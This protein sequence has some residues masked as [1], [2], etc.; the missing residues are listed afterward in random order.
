MFIAFNEYT[1]ARDNFRVRRDVRE[2]RIKM[3]KFIYLFIYFS[4]KSKEG[5]MIKY[6]IKWSNAI[7]SSARKK[8]KKINRIKMEQSIILLHKI[9]RTKITKV[10]IRF[11]NWNGKFSFIS[12]IDLYQFY[13]R[14]THTVIRKIV[15]IVD[16]R[17]KEGEDTVK[18]RASSWKKKK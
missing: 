5:T 14:N 12:K 9:Y 7:L 11:K 17:F 18:R 1:E 15:R 10:I 3:G 8:E 4:L 16:Q 6:I 13:K 2:E